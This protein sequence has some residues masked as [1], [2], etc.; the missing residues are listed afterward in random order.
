MIS[1]NNMIKTT[2]NNNYVCEGYLSRNVLYNR[3]FSERNIP[4]EYFFRWCY[5][6]GDCN[7]MAFEV[8][9]FDGD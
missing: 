7:D 2:G 1:N 4:L 3:Y 6:K 5:R 8:N 9:L